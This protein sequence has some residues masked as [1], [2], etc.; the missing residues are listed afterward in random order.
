MIFYTLQAKAI[1]VTRMTQNQ[2]TASAKL[3]FTRSMSTIKT[4]ENGVKYGQS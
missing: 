4:L 3:T 2:V 1:K